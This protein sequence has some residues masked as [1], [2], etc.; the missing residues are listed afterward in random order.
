MVLTAKGNVWSYVFGYVN[1]VLYAY[2]A[3]RNGLYGEMGLN[4]FFF[5]PSGILGFILWKRNI[6]KAGQL[7]MRKLT[8]RG[9][10]LTAA[11]CIISIAAMGY[12][13][14][15]IQG[16]NTPYID[17]TTNV[18]SIVATILTLLRYREQWLLYITLN[19][20]TI[21]MW[22]IRLL[23]GSPDGIL[24]IVMWSAYLINACY[25][26]YN[27]SKGVKALEEK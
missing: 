22:V 18:L 3:Y 8:W 19:L 1:T 13:L 9:N 20:F 10:L 21:L 25:G 12:G 23:H 4:L 17:A 6:R 11:I 16:Q 27:W 2:I 5:L 26:F 7:I 24:M 15:L 14:S